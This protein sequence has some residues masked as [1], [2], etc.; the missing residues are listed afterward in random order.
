LYGASTGD[1]WRVAGS[2]PEARY[3]T[4]RFP[5]D[6]TR[7]RPAASG[8]SSHELTATTCDADADAEEHLTST[9][10]NICADPIPHHGWGAE[11][12]LRVARAS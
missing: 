8:D 11:A 9:Y 6:A 12:I 10:R 7:P 3:R 4:Y 5:A 2:L 1:D